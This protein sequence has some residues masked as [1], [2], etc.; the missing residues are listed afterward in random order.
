MFLMDLAT[1]VCNLCY[2]WPSGRAPLTVNGTLAAFMYI[3]H[4]LIH[5][6]SIKFEL[7]GDFIVKTQVLSQIIYV[8]IHTQIAP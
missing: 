1:R 5:V 2:K 7:K 4:T 3:N 8:I 6:A